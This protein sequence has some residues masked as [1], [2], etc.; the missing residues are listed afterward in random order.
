[1]EYREN[2]QLRLAAEFVQ[3]TNKNIFITGRA[4][5]GKTTFLHN[6]KKITPKRMVVVAPTGV[7]AIN[8][9][10]VTIHSFFQLNFAPAIPEVLRAKKADASAE[11]Y[12][13]KFSRNKIKLIKCI[14]LLV[15]DEI[16]MVRADILD[17]VDEVLRRY[18]NRSKPFGGV[19]L[20]MI[21]DLHQLTPVIKDDE[22]NILKEFY[23]S[24]YFFDSFAL[25]KSQHVSIELKEIFRQ[26]DKHFIGLLNKVRDN[27]TDTAT[28]AEINTRHIP[29]FRAKDEDGY[30]T[31]TTHNAGANSINQAKLDELKDVSQFFDADIEGE[32]SPNDFPTDEKLELKVGSQVMFIKNDPSPEKLYY[33]GKI[34]KITRMEDN[35]VFVKC[36]SDNE[37]IEVCK[38]A[39]ENVR[40]SLNED[41]REIDE[42]VIGTFSQIPLRLAWAI[43]IHKSQ[44]L[45]FDKV[46]IDAHAAF[47]FGQV[48]VALSRCRTFEGIVLSTPISVAG[49][50]TDTL[51]AEYTEDVRQ[52]EPGPEKLREARK[53]FQQDLIIELFD[54]NLLK[55]RFD[56]LLKLIRENAHVL[57]ASKVI[58]LEEKR[59]LFD[60]D[61]LQV[62]EK[63]KQQLR[64]IMQQDVLPQE[65][66]ALQERIRK[67]SQYFSTNIKTKLSDY[68]NTIFFD[69]DNK[70]IKKDLAESLEKLQKETFIKYSCIKN[71]HEGFDTLSY[72]RQ[73]SDA[74]MDFRPP[75][76]KA[77]SQPVASAQSKHP[78]LYQALKQWRNNLAEENNLP[79]YQIL[80]QKTITE[81]VNKLPTTLQ[82][83]KTI[84]GIGKVK[85]EIY[86][87]EII[88]L[89]LEY[90]RDHDV[91]AEQIEIPVKAK[92]E[93]NPSR[94][95]SLDLYQAGKSI[96]E[97]AK[98]R[99]FSI[100][101]IEGHLAHFVGRGILDVKAFVDEEKIKKVLTML[102]ADEKKSLG[103]IKHALGEEISYN[104]LNFVVQHYKHL[105]EE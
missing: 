83:L 65:N 89:I 27:Q 16:S 40:Y 97:I 55:Y 36:P 98:E 23:D 81:L 73:R 76:Y 99:G 79:V 39:W 45:T 62:A 18:R 22:W 53:I 44:G 84:K 71:T 25:K 54:F 4:G 69:T 63:F 3:Y 15:I 52:N 38:V 47:A 20:L 26:T 103:E 51:V 78:V 35:V 42:K 37:E 50:K 49:I 58:D 59:K 104:E 66:P 102:S 24:I 30:I 61:L 74:E 96:A 29:G 56:D 72:L 82:A 14:D 93:K 2:E 86:G 77:A 64:Y 95:V 34:G 87:P 28:I 12:K 21:G 43:T 33:N 100:T 8:A 46:I 17:A 85:S 105:Q 19:Q 32:F 10:G 1:M 5:T 94:N 13:H 88:S 6:L 41:T 80:P 11:G 31:L 70:A 9:G 90:C 60:T 91:V 68:L 67:A 92:K 7:A 48:Y 57:E 101:T 75:K